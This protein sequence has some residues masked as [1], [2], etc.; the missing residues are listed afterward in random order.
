MAPILQ[1]ASVMH[2]PFL[3]ATRRHLVAVGLVLSSISGVARAEPPAAEKPA[4]PAITESSAESTIDT[5]L[6]DFDDVASSERSERGG[7][8]FRIIAGSSRAY[9]DNTWVFG[10]GLQGE[11]HLG[12]GVELVAGAG[13]LLGENSE[14]VPVEVLIQTSV[15][16]DDRVELY[17]EIGP[18]AA[19]VI[20]HG[21]DPLMLFGGTAAI[22]FLIRQTE[23]FGIFIQPSYQVLVE[24][25][26][27]VH[28]LEGAVGVN[29]RF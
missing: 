11:L 23:A 16:L 26:K 18:L 6:H 12:R 28:D 8:A 20:E 5:S 24:D 17:F 19:L 25:Q 7:V 29:W 27:P 4:P 21:H 15:K 13:L 1:P 3:Q 2:A 10:F 9:P 22:G 14:I